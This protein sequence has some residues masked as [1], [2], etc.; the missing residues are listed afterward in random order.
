MVRVS[1][2]A[3]DLALIDEVSRR[4][5]RVTA[6]QFER[7]RACGLLPRP[8]HEP[9]NGR[10][11]RTSYGQSVA[12]IAEHVAAVAHRSRRG[13][14]ACVTAV[15][16]TADGCPVAD[17]LLE[18]GYIYLLDEVI[19]LLDEAFAAAST[20]YVDPPQDEL[21][22]A[23]RVAQALLP[24]LKTTMRPW[25]ANVRRAHLADTEPVSS[26]LASAV[27]A[28]VQLLRGSEPDPDAIF[29]M[30]TAM[31]TTEMTAA[32]AL[33]GNGDRPSPSLEPRA[34]IAA[35]FGEAF[36]G[37]PIRESLVT[38]RMATAREIRAA[39]LL[40]TTLWSTLTRVDVIPDGLDIVRPSG[41]RPVM[42]ALAIALLLR[43]VDEDAIEVEPLCQIGMDAGWF[44]ATAAEQLLAAAAILNQRHPHRALV[45]QS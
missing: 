4:G 5:V 43:V 16:V 11:S 20:G 39:G 36:V 3:V 1:P 12:Q 13:L 17:A 14:R 9:L 8:T 29:E 28:V 25:I 31:G 7:W 37:R 2:S 35:L 38:A 41:D 21:E 15:A 18:Q 33:A 19:V 45:V 10:G 27:T 23:E 24:T 34:A 32:I 30:T 44:D 6:S 22:A 40:T 42:Y 26:V